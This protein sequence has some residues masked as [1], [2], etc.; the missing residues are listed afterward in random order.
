MRVAPRGCCTAVA[1]DQLGRQAVAVI[2]VFAYSFV[3][4]YVLGKLVDTTIGFRISEEE[5]LHGVDETTH[6]ES[7]YDL[8]AIRAGGFAATATRSAVPVGLGR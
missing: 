7:A 5:E 3:L 6:A 4:S 2:A 8:A 1:L